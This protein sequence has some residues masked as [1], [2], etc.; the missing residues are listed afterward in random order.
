MKAIGYIRVSTTRQDLERQ[1]KL[2]EDYCIMKNYSIVDIFS[3]KQTGATSNRE[4]YIKLLSTNKSMADVIIVSEL[5]RLSREDEI[6]NTLTQINMILQNGL[7]VVFLDDES[8]TYKG[9]S[10]LVLIDIITLSVKAQQAADE[11]KKIKTRMITG[12]QVQSRKLC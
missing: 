1:K 3:D 4:G 9:G 11:R 5:S 10:S 6:M 8:K 12:R 2:I 7:D